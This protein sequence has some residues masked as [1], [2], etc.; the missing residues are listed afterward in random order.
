MTT[1]SLATVPEF[2]RRLV[3]LGTPAMAV[4]PLRALVSS[5]FDIALVVSGPDRRRG[6]GNELSPSPV[7]AAALALDLAVSERVEDVLGVGAD[8]GVVVAYGSLVRRPVLEQVPM[9][10][11]HFSLLPRWRGAAPVER[12]ILAGDTETGTCL[13]QL[14]E[15]LDTGPVFDTIRVPIRPRASADEVRHELVDAGVEQL[16]RRLASG[17]R[18][19]EPQSG[20]PTYASKIRPEELR[21]DWDAPAVVIHR[22]VRLGTAWT[23]L[24]GRRLRIHTAVPDGAAAPNTPGSLEGLRVTCGD[25]QALL[26]EMVQPEGKAAMDAKS[27]VHGARPTVG[28]L[29]GH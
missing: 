22:L 18:N 7:K 5:G 24:R 29:L 26:L 9:I 16:L 23:S 20:E 14:E 25:G 4:P 6:R 12:A 8:L 10:N 19:P 2:P 21:I 28:E 3:Y 1:T 17:L 11:I 27:W 15:G 13:M